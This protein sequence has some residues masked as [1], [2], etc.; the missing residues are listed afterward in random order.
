MAG[1]LVFEMSLLRLCFDEQKFFILMTFNQPVF[2]VWLTAYLGSFFHIRLRNLFRR[3][4]VNGPG[5]PA[6]GGRA[7]IGPNSTE[8]YLVLS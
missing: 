7:F 5:G 8:R 4:T 1:E 3:S 2:Y 6:R